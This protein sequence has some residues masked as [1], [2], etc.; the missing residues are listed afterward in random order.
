MILF[1]VTLDPER[2]QSGLVPD[3]KMHAIVQASGR[4]GAKQ[5]AAPLLYHWGDPDK[6][7]VTPLTADGERVAIS[8]E[9]Y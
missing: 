7:V 4:E 8:V 2:Q 5:I 9:T 1:L 6:Y 3:E